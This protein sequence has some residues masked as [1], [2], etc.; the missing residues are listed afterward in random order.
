LFFLLPEETDEEEDDKEEDDKEE[1][2]K[3]ED[4]PASASQMQYV[5][6]LVATSAMYF[7]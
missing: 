6:A 3:E 1:D 7:W 4:K 2:D 5:A